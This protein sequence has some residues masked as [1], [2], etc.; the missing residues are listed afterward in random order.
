VQDG[1]G[2]VLGLDDHLCLGETRLEVAAFVAARFLEERLLAD[3]LL[4]VEQRLELLPLDVDQIEGRSRPL[5]RVRGDSRDRRAVE[6]RLEREHVAIVRTDCA[7]DAGSLQRTAQLQPLHAR[8]CEGAAQHRGVQHPRERE[9]C[10]VERLPAGTLVPVLPRRRPTHDRAR[11]LRPLLERVVAL[12]D[13]PLLGV[14]ALDL[15]LGPDQ[16]RHVSTAS[17]ILG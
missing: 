7:E 6:A 14:V 1:L 4:G 5:Q 3:S 15:F 2:S 17:S 8:A 13:H 11:P 9:V 10:G 16:S 12:D